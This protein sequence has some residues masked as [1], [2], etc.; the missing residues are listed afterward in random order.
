MLLK[1]RGKSILKREWLI[2][3]DLLRVRKMRIEKGLFD[4]VG[5]ACVGVGKVEVII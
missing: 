2:G 4:L 1:L 5:R 3:L